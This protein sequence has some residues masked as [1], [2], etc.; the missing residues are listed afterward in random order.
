[1]RFWSHLR[2]SR[3]RP[4]RRSAPPAALRS[5]IRARAFRVPHV[6]ENL[7]VYFVHGASAGGRRAA[8]PAG[9]AGQGPGAGDRDRPGQRA[10][11]REHRRRAGVRPGRR[12]RQ[13]RQAGP[14]ADGEPAAA[15][16]IGTRADRLVLRRAGPLVGARQGGP[17][18]SSRAPG[19]RCRRARRCWPWRRRRPRPRPSRRS[20][21]PAA[22]T[23]SARAGDEIADKQQQVWDSVAATQSK[24]SAGLDAACLAAIGHQPAALAREREAQGGARRLYRGA[25]AGRREGRTTSSATSS[26]S[27]AR[28][29]PP[30]SIPPTA[31]FR[32]MWAKQ[33][34]AVVTEA[35][36]EKPAPRRAD[37][38]HAGAGRAG[39]SW[40]RPRRASPRSGRLPPAC[41]RRRA[42][43]TRRSTTRPAAP[44]AT[45]STA[46]TWRSKPGFGLARHK[47]LP[48]AK[49]GGAFLYSPLAVRGAL[50][51]SVQPGF[52]AARSGLRC[53]MT[54]PPPPKTASPARPAPICCSTRTTP[55][56]GGRGG[57]RRWPRPSAPTS[58]SCSRSATPPAT[59][60]TSWRTRASR[61]TATA[62]LMNEL[63]VNIKVDREERPDIDAI[64]M[65]A[66]HSLGEQGG[67][68]LTMFLDSEARPFW[69]GTYFPPEP[70]YGRPG[71]PH[72]LRE[73]AR[74]YREEPD[75]VSHNAG[76]LVA[77][78]RR[79]R[80]EA[81]PSPTI[82]DAGA[83]RSHPAH[84]QR[85][86]HAPRRPAGAPKFPQWSFFWLLWRGAIRYGHDGGQARRRHHARQHL[87]GR[88]LRSP[89]RR[90]RALLGRRALARPAL[91]EDAL[92]QR[93]AHRPDVRGLPRDRQRALRA[94]A[95]RRPSRWLL[96]EMIAEGG[97]FAAS[98][99]ADSEG[100]EG[101]FYVWTQ[102]RDRRGA[103]RGRRR[104]SSARPTT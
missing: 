68:P 97:G 92:R 56:T 6:H 81:V 58:R 13:G 49:G 11:D 100:E 27:T 10:A 47:A 69:G 86:R 65:R 40:P 30:T 103:G 32:K 96:R 39:R 102:G 104:S 16:E 66:L 60:A 48:P 91:R 8:H 55:C 21:R 101:K 75:K 77:G 63:F 1:M 85:R 3:R 43:P 41:A 57:R 73:V 52:A 94:R 37:A 22:A 67:W 33:L 19:R 5:P 28:W 95:S 36:G 18:P 9:G 59:G 61:T 25:E 26:P 50:L 35:I 44:T 23:R 71:F 72:V 76:L 51:Q 83:G 53:P 12:H 34:A 74:I 24:L 4:W 70:R 87:P 54:S 17:M 38:A 64:Y 14:R 46:A 29:A 2:L 45:G 84:G 99:D 78:A 42:T 15:A 93:A 98:L 20:E 80:A 89:R 62:A 88:H 82:D 90:L 79:T 7:A 31:L